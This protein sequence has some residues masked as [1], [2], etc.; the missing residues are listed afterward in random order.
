MSDLLWV[1]IG[2]AIGAAARYVLGIWI[3]GRIG[4]SFPWNTMVVNI[5]GGLA[6]GISLTLLTER[7]IADPAWRLLLVVG[8]LGGYTTFS[9]Y[10]FEALALL[11]AGAWFSA[12]WYV[13]GSN[14]LGLLATYLGI[15]LA[16]VLIH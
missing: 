2:G 5:S 3:I 15:V 16:R 6:I 7:I 9:S 10:T 1:S 8:F 4:A 11:E 12:A 13:L 14:G